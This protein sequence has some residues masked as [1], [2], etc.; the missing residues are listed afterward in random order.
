MQKVKCSRKEAVVEKTEQGPHL[1]SLP[2]WLAFHLLQEA[3]QTTPAPSQ[4]GETL[5]RG[6]V[7]E[8]AF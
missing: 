3:L 8:R 5:L 4:L 2:A 6:A 7:K 1:T